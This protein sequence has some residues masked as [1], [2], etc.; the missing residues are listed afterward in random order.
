MKIQ[1]EKSLTK[2]QNQTLIQIKRMENY[3]HIFDLESTLSYVENDGLNQ[4]L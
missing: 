1:K 3:C 4:V 2:W